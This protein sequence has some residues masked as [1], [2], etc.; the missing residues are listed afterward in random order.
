VLERAAEELHPPVRQARRQQRDDLTVGG[1]GIPEWILDR[2]ALETG[3][4]VEI[5]IEPL[6]WLSQRGG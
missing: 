6:E 2:V 4:V 1:A 3:G 5:A